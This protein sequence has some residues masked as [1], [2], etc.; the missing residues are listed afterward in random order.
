MF[1]GYAR[2]EGGGEVSVVG[3][4]EGEDERGWVVKLAVCVH[5]RPIRPEQPLLFTHP[6]QYGI[7]I[8]THVVTN[9]PRLL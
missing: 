7:M 9:I 8:K 1:W 5:P 2:V 4:E 3:E 6:S